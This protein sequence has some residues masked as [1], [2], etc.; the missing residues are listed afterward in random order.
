M[1]RKPEEPYAALPLLPPRGE[2]ETRA[3]LK[4][5]VAARDALG[6]FDARARALPNPTILINAI[7]LLEAQ[8]SSEIENIV[9]TTDE[10]FSAAASDATATPQAK[11]ALRY[12]SALRA[13]F[14]ALERRPLTGVSAVE[15]C[16]VL[17]GHDEG[18]RRGPVF[19][20]NPETH[21]RVY[22]PPATKADIERLLANWTEFVNG[23]DDLDPLVRMAVAHYQFE[24]IHPFTDGNGR[25]GRVLNVLMLCAAGL[26]HE[27][28][29]YLS[30]HIIATK[31]EYY[32]LLREVTA[33]E[34]W[35]EWILY[36]LEGVRATSASAIDLVDRIEA[37]QATLLDQVR[38]V[39]GTANRDLL[40]VL[41]EQPYA[42]TRDVVERAGVSRPTASK[43]LRA[44]VE[45]GALIEVKAGRELLYINAALMAALR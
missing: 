36:M 34:A 2:L 15:I 1:T 42:R 17:R 10:L 25:T 22:T 9:T 5:T 27:P 30:R 12:R 28:L 38:T 11:E 20:G 13:G 37:V 24:A 16:A 41:M 39:I 3:V 26:L 44:L 32:R 18:I 19:I 21:S 4:A 6:R 31:E 43:W 14:D 33:R 35:E 23:D 8:A 7:P 40:D 29:L 45:A